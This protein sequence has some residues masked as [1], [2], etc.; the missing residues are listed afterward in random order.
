MSYKPRR[1]WMIFCNIVDGQKT[2]CSQKA[3]LPEGFTLTQPIT[4]VIPF[5]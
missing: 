3:D 1:V 5:D 4:E 2:Q